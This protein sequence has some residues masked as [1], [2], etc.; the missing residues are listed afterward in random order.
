MLLSIRVNIYVCEKSVLNINR[1]C[2]NDGNLFGSLLLAGK[3]LLRSFSEECGRDYRRRK[4][5]SL[6]REYKMRLFV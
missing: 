4:G 3:E 5:R 2:F 6:I 1:M